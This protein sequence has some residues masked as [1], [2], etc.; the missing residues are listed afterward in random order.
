M[1]Y[2]IIRLVV[3]ILAFIVGVSTYVVWERRQEIINS[4]TELILNYQD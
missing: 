2:L 4:C 3:A 1:Q